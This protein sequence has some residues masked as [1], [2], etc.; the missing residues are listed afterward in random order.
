M[1]LLR[2][3][4]K[5]Q[6]LVRI[7][8]TPEEMGR[9]AAKDAAEAIRQVIACK[10]SVNILFAAAP[11]QDTFLAAL[12]E[13]SSIEWEKINA[14]QLDDY[15]G[16]SPEAPQRFSNYLYRHIFS[17]RQPASCMMIDVTNPPE[18]EIERYTNILEQYSAD[19]AFIGIGENGHIAFNDP[20]VA[21][22]QDPALIRQITM[23][24]TSRVQQVNDG[25]FKTLS[26]VPHTALT[27][28]IPAITSAQYVFCM[29]PNSRKAP[30]VQATVYGDITENC[31][32][33]ILRT[34][35][36][37]TLY[38]DSDSASLLK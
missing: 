7:Y 18:T 1:C 36:Q 20:G 10:G 15:V 27:L 6:L 12:A 22:F 31:P 4:G 26:E 9:S 32:A 16:I 21:N 30:A 33:S 28:T 11:S 23:E 8:D 35:P 24:E 5:D 17:K 34:H 37:A 29:V 3:F 25:C 38:L 2:E 13:D 19:I 14:M